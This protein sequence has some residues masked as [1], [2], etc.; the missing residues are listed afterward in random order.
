MAAM[1]LSEPG[2]DYGPCLGECEHT[3][4]AETR[5]QAVAKCMKCDE[6]IGYNRLFYYGP[7]NPVHASCMGACEEDD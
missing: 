4:C 2:T 7:L 3:D 5:L 6:A 1:K